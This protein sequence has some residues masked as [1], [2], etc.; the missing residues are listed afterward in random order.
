MFVFIRVWQCRL[1]AHADQYMSKER[2]PF[3]V[4]CVGVCG[5]GGALFHTQPVGNSSPSPL[6]VAQF[7]YPAI[8]HSLFSPA[9]WE[10]EQR[11]PDPWA[12]RKSVKTQPKPAACLQAQRRAADTVETKSSCSPACR[13]WSG[14]SHA[15]DRPHS[16]KIGTHL[17]GKPDR[18]RCSK[19]ETNRSAARC[20]NIVPPLVIQSSNLNV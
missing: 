14:V 12:Q 11:P 1:C 3:K 4:L 6:V 20:W 15:Y 10:A 2:L 5:R 13:H 17:K 16:I 19:A 9:A 8:L 7:A 18:N